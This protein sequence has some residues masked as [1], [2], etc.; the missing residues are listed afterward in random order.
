MTYFP[1]QD[2]INLSAL[3]GRLDQLYRNTDGHI[4]YV[5][6][7]EPN[8]SEH[9]YALV[10]KEIQ[11]VFSNARERYAI[12][13]YQLHY[14]DLNKEQKDVVHRAVPFRITEVEVDAD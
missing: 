6:A 13:T 9:K 10:L 8:S 4:L 3:Y 7:Y 14:R 1:L 11:T 12:E 2:L 5:L